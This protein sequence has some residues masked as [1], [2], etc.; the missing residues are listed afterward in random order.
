MNKKLDQLFSFRDNETFQKG[1]KITGYVLIGLSAILLGFICGY[2][3]DIMRPYVFAFIPL[4]LVFSFLRKNDYVYMLAE[5]FTIIADMFLILQIKIGNVSVMTL[6]MP[7]Y[8]IVQLLYATYF[9]F[10]DE[11]KKRQ[12]I[13][14]ITRA[15]LSII[16]AVVMVVAKKTDP[17]FIL[18][19]IY[20]VNI[21]INIACAAITKDPI[22]IVGF[23]IF[24]ISDAFIGLSLFVKSTSS[25]GKFLASFNFVYFFYIISQTI[26]VF[27]N[28]RNNYICKK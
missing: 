10:R 25:L 3:K 14:I 21:L 28:H 15:V 22:L 11:N 19:A 26:L 6:G 4:L 24:A 13:L 1:I 9:Y 17:K 20:Y 16:G 27:N 12:L 18:G 7:F 2:S 8:I 5:F 23:A